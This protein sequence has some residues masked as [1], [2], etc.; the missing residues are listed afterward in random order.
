[1]SKVITFSTSFPP[2]HYRAGQPTYF[3][4]KLCKALDE[5]KSIGMKHQISKELIDH[6]NFAVYNDCDPKY[7]TIRAGN[8]FKE[9]EYFSPR[10]WGNNVN[11]KSKRSGPYHSNQIIL[12]PESC[13]KKFKL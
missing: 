4:E 5:N 13:Q 3:V 11:P 7:T 1:M 6:F 12:V 9:G 8:R 2:Y 10:I